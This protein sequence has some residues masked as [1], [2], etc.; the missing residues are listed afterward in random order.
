MNNFVVTLFPDNSPELLG[1]LSDILSASFS[2][3]AAEYDAGL[4]FISSDSSAEAI[5][6]E[7]APQLELDLPNSFFV[8]QLSGMWAGFGSTNTREAL[9]E[10]LINP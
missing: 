8:F 6:D 5:F 4:F 7:V 10:R 3:W 1:Q 2:V 9:S